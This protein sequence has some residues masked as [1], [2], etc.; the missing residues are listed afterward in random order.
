MRG[1]EQA[2][3]KTNDDSV[4][5]RIYAALGGAELVYL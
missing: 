4:Q 2:I 3:V 5:W 1:G